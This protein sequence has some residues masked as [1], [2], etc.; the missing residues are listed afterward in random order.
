MHSRLYAPAEGDRLSGSFGIIT[1][2][3]TQVL[4]V[5][6]LHIVVY[7]KCACLITWR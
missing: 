3:V 5:K 1:A 2:V 6:P 7:T 4:Q